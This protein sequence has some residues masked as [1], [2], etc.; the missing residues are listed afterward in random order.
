MRGAL[1]RTLADLPVELLA[2]AARP[3]DGA[4]DGALLLGLGRLR[5]GAVVEADHDVGAELELEVD[6]PLGR[7]GPLLAGRGLA[8]DHLVV[9]DHAALRV[10]ADQAPDLEPAGVADRIGPSQSMNRCTPPAACMTRAPG[11]AQEVE[12][13]DDQALDADGAE[14][15]AA[16]AAHAG[17]RGVR[18]EGRHRQRPAAGVERIS[19]PG[20]ARRRARS[21]P[22][23]PPSRGPGRHRRRAAPGARDTSA[24][25]RGHDRRATAS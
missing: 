11:P 3:A 25:C 12:R 17:A 2:A 4:L 23:P 6:D 16:D 18:H 14:V 10:L 19:H 5:I 13:V 22:M 1:A 15:V 8:K 21:G 9:A 7:Q 20:S 24:P